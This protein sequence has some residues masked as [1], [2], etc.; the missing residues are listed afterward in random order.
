MT[1]KLYLV[2]TLVTFR[3]QYVV[4]ADCKDH[5][6]DEVTMLDSGNPDDYFDWAAQKCLGE[7]IIDGRKISE[8]QFNKLLDQMEETGEGSHWMGKDL[9]RKINYDR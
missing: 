9:I 6:F 3:N 4:E 5:A 2:E 7:T 8:K 1:K